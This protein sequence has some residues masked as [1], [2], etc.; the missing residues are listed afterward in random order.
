[1][2]GSK[3]SHANR[4]TQDLTDIYSLPGWSGE[5]MFAYMRKV[6]TS[7]RL[8]TWKS[9]L[10]MFR[11]RP[12]TTNHGSKQTRKLMAMTVR[13]TRSPMTWPRSPSCCLSP[14]NPWA[15]RWCTTCSA[16]E[17]PRM[18]VDTFLGL[19]RSRTAELSRIRKLIMLLD[20]KGIRTT[21]ADFV[22]NARHRNNIDIAVETLVDKINFEEKNGELHATS[23]TLVDKSGAKRKVKARKEIIVSAGRRMTLTV[24]TRP[25]PCRN[26]LLS[27][28][29]SAVRD[30]PEK[31]TRELRNPVP[32]RLAWRRKE[33]A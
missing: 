16:P 4:A 3:H 15:C 11:A 20:H 14:W 8:A 1:M 21:A 33:P 17:K 30:W 23:V 26:I 18:A 31:R 10:T 22:T 6:R 25:D 32:C 28:N 9:W 27:S 13:F 24:L 5:E 12:S 19:V 7:L 29:S 2:T